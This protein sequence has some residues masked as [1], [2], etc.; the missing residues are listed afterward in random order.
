MCAAP[1]IW[2]MLACGAPSGGPLGVV[3]WVD[4]GAIWAIAKPSRA[5]QNPSWPVCSP[6]GAYL[7]A[8]GGE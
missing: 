1:W 8:P 4:T 3:F 6:R 2:A 5:V 7:K